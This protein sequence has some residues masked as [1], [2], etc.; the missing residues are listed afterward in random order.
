MRLLNWDKFIF[1]TDNHGDM[2]DPSAITACSRF[3]DIWKPTIRVHGGDNFD[4]RPLR[5]KASEE[6]RRELMRADFDAG[7]TFF[8]MLRPTHY[9]RG[10]HC[11]RLWDLAKSKNGP[12][13]EYAG[14]LA[15]EV[16]SKLAKMRC[17]M[18]PYDRRAGVLKI[19]KLKLIHGYC[20][21]VTAARRSAQAYGSVLM[22]HAHSIQSS[23]IEGLHNRVGRIVGCLCLLDM[24]Y[25][26][27]TLAS[28]V[29][30]HGFAYGVVNRKT[31]E[32]QVWQAES[33]NGTWIIP[34]DVIQL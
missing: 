34:S 17:I 27:A 33:I 30:R 19:G 9:L 22:G 13:S 29:H 2:A 14:S 23:S 10:N 12:F 21:G 1:A 15:T 5:R 25:S 11:E 8:E 4:F 26:R 31:G 18:Q 24:E 3:V 6:D 16:E 7:M 28:L 32:Y 20:A